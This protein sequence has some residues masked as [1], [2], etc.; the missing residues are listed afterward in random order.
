MRRFPSSWTETLSRL[1]FRRKRRSQHGANRFNM[2]RRPQIESLEM[3]AMLATYTVDSTADTIASDGV[4]TFREALASAYTNA[5][6]DT[7]SFSSTV[8]NV[9]KTITLAYD[10]GD[11]GSVPDQLTID[12]NV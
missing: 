5:G 7:I 4:T 2:R 1:G 3:R 10:G 12:S 6:P 8:F 9:P 11:A